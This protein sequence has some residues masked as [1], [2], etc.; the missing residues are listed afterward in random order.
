MI[1]P[2]AEPSGL[3][4]PK[5]KE[6]IMQNVNQLK[7]KWT[8]AA[9]ACAL[10]MMAMMAMLTAAPAWAHTAH[11]ENKTDK[12]VTV[13][14]WETNPVGQVTILAQ[15]ELAPNGSFSVTGRKLSCITHYKGWYSASTPDRQ[16]WKLKPGDCESH[17]VQV[18]TNGDGKFYFEL[19]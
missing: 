17:R 15:K 16:S 3:A 1:D 8:P 4:A 7:R 19:K 14:V 12:T 13:S 10:A 11:V 2:N 5:E 18:K 6:T 9:L